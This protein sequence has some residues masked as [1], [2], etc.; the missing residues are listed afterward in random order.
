MGKGRN[1]CVARGAKAA[2]FYVDPQQPQIV[3]DPAPFRALVA[4]LRT[5]LSDTL[6]DKEVGYSTIKQAI[7]QVEGILSRL[8]RTYSVKETQ[9]LE[10]EFLACSQQIIDALAERRR[11]KEAAAELSQESHSPARLIHQA[12]RGR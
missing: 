2:L 9:Q 3:T 5:E 10:E 12:R 11:C 8:Q 6:Q 4:Q 1:G 7:R